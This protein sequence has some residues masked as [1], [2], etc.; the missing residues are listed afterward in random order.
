MSYGVLEADKKSQGHGRKY[1]A[2]MTAQKFYIEHYNGRRDFSGI[3]LG[4]LT[5]T[6]AKLQGCNFAGCNLR[7][8]N[9][10]ASDLTDCNFEGANVAYADFSGA[11][12]VRAKFLMVK[13]WQRCSREHAKID[14]MELSQ[15]LYSKEY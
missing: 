6:H 1:M 9:F 13:N 8:T 14:E 5:L 12:L 15:D 2:E 11:T 4:G 3:N 10:W 7:Y